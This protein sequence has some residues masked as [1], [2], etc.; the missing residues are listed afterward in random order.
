MKLPNL[1]VC[2]IYE[3]CPDD[4]IKLNVTSRSKLN[5]CRKLSPFNIGPVNTIINGKLYESKNFE[6]LWQYSK[7]YS[8]HKSHDEWEKWAINGFDNFKAVR[9]PFGRGA[10]PMH[11]LYENEK[12]GYIEAR[13]YIY[14]KKYSEA[15]EF[16]CKDELN[17]IKLML[18]KGLKIALCDFDGYVYQ[19]GGLKLED[20][21]YNKKRKFGHSFVIAGLLTDNKFWDKPF[22]GDKIFEKSIPKLKK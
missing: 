17:K 18:S 3:S 7:F 13:Y 15:L 4:Y 1:I 12:L 19:M 6:N 8:S 10:K 22:D 9:F 20:T 21:I 16:Y 14:A 5:W 11:S 2:G